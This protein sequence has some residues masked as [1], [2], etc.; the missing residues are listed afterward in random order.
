MLDWNKLDFNDFASNVRLLFETSS[1]L[2]NAL[3]Y[4]KPFQTTLELIESVSKI[5]K[6]LSLPDKIDILNA[7]PQIGAPKETLSIQSQSEQLSKPVSNETLQKLKEM[8]ER[9]EAKFGFRFVVF[10]NGRSRLD[11]VS[12]FKDRLENTREEELEIAIKE[13][14]L[15]AKDRLPRFVM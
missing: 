2:E 15:I 10:V 13:M 8:N 7:H 3:F 12:V 5:F 4:A 9:Y 1:V 6:S 14:V 11:I